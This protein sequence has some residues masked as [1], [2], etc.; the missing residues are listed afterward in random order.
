VALSI[1]VVDDDPAFRRV[2]GHM[3]AAVGL[4]VVGEAGTAED[5]AAAA[6]ELRPDAALV[7]VG[8]PDEDG[9]T[10][11]CKLARLPEPPRVLL[12][13]T[14]PQAATPNDVRASGATG[15][16]AKEDLPDAPLRRLLVAELDGLV[17]EE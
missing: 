6:C 15:F 13:S 2:A 17:T 3:L 14:D 10:L 16:V 5:A 4:V 9:V 11:A 7:D 8:L 1:L 12:T